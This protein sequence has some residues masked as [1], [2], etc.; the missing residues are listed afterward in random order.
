MRPYSALAAAV[1]AA[2]ATLAAAVPATAA[3]WTAP[4]TVSAPHTFISGLE[5]ASSGNGTLVA[6]WRFQDGV[7]TAAAT[8]ARGAALAPGAAAFGGERTLPGATTQV[9]PYAQRSVAALL[10]TSLDP[11][12]QSAEHLSAKSRL[13]LVSLERELAIP[14][15]LPGGVVRLRTFFSAPRENCS[16]ASV[17]RIEDH[18][19]RPCY[20]PAFFLGAIVTVIDQ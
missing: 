10:Q 6:D 14:K 4:A 15:T 19:L 12:G 16:V 2:A 5:A 17:W 9:V 1:T 7:G 13:Q 20:G 18:F 11:A 8:G 3:T